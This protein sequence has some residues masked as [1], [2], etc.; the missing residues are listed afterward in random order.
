[1]VTMLDDDVQRFTGG[2]QQSDDMTILAIK[3]NGE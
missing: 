1:M 3:V 2:H